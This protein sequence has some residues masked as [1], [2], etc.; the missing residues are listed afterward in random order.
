MRNEI[1]KFVSRKIG[2]LTK[3][4]DSGG[5]KAMLAQLRRGVGKQPGELPE[6]W[7]V[8]LRE[9]PEE[10]MSKTA[11]PS[12]AEWA[13]YTALTLF[14]LHQQGHSEPMN[15]T[16]AEN[17]F[18]CAARKLVHDN[19]DDEEE[20]IRFKLSLVAGSDDMIELSYRLKSIVQLLSRENIGLDYVDLAKDVF[21][22]QFDE[23]SDS[24]R[25][26]WGQD[27]YRS[28]KTDDV[29]KDDKNEE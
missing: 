5:S 12:R 24:V 29:G 10:M 18:G 19:S 15:E 26:K 28:F 13:V 23:Y 6:L 17:R 20:R 14:A 3:D 1:G 25:L 22:F 16:G 2:L 4:I 27:F 21:T 7:G 8:F 9:M 11:Y